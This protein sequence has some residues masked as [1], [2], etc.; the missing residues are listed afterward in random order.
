LGK[1][2]KGPKDI[3]AEQKRF[4]LSRPVTSHGFGLI[5]TKHSTGGCV[6]FDEFNKSGFFSNYYIQVVVFDFGGY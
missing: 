5:P 4:S 2:K 3:P 6:P 1:N